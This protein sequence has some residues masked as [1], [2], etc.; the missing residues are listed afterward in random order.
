MAHHK[1]RKVTFTLK[2]AEYAEMKKKDIL[3]KIFESQKKK[4]E[5]TE[6]GEFRTSVLSDSQFTF[7]KLKYLQREYESLRY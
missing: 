6:N 1:T 2:D 7:N 5:V 4:V 3:E